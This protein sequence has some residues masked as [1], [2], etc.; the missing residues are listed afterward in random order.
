MPETT[1]NDR[2]LGAVCYLSFFVFVPI[3]AVKEKGAFLA[4]HC[5]QGFALFFAEVVLY[6]VLNI[7]DA[8]LGRLPLIGLLLTIVLHLVAMIV[9]LTLSV[10]GFVKALSGEV[11]RL[12]IIDEFAD[13]VPIT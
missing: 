13:R 6:V 2:W 4:G 11:C 9:C 7:I 1:N 8:T 3:L 12:P 5:R 10:I